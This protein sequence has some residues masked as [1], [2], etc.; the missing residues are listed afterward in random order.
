MLRSSGQEILPKEA[1]IPAAIDLRHATPAVTVYAGARALRALSR[2]LERA[3]ARSVV[4]VTS[5]SLEGTRPHQLVLEAV[6]ER[7]ANS[8]GGVKQFS[9]TDVVVALAEIITAVEADALVVVG[10]GSAMVTARSAAVLAGEGRP[11]DELLTR[12]DDSGK[13]VNPRM[14]RPKVP[15]WIVPSTP[16]PAMA[17]AGS[18]LRQSGTGKRVAIFDPKARAAGVVIDPAALSSS[19]TSLFVAT[20][21]NGLSMGIEGLLATSDDPFAEALLFQGVREIVTNLRAVAV[22]SESWQARARVAMGSILTGQGSDYSGA[23]L[24]LALSHEIAPHSAV[25]GGVVESV[26][27]PHTVRF[28]AGAVPHRI[29]IVAAALGATDHTLDGV[30]AALR[31]FGGT[32]GLPTTLRDTG[33][34]EHDLKAAIEHAVND[35]AMNSRMPRLATLQDLEAIANDAW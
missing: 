13:V 8:F 20:A 28:T 9:P 10:G 18:A 5:P 21:M 23:G 27:L 33:I 7:L 30:A 1:A 14:P 19:P 22:D 25:A 29:P 11:I 31:D 16:T 34:G 26:L 4:V 35:W 12:R 2:E 15:I 32:L 17:K 3:G 24:A 6:G